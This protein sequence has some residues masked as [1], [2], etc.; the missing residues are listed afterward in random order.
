RLFLGAAG[1]AGSTTAA[2]Q[3]SYSVLSKSNAR[4]P[5]STDSGSHDPTVQTN[6]SSLTHK[7]SADSFNT[8]AI[9]AAAGK[10][11]GQTHER[12]AGRPP[13]R[14]PLPSPTLHNTPPPYLT[15]H[16][17]TGS[18]TALTR[19]LQFF[20]CVAKRTLDDGKRLSSYYSTPLREPNIPELERASKTIEK[21]ESAG[22]GRFHSSCISNSSLRDIEMGAIEDELT[23]YM[24]EIRKRELCS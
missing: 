2:P 4:G 13:S 20:H 7:N 17:G 24:K 9:Q 1:S 22:R 16:V 18:S 19:F 14:I 11:R 6:A 15:V 12:R 23:A 10:R 21:G 8:A 5:D 3:R